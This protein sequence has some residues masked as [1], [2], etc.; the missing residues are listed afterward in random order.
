[1]ATRSREQQL[2]RYSAVVPVTTTALQTPSLSDTAGLARGVFIVGNDGSVDGG[3]IAPVTITRPANTTAYSAVDVVGGVL[4]ISSVGPAS[5]TAILTGTRLEL[6]IAAV[7][8]GM[9]YFTLHIYSATP[10]S[11]YADNAAWDL[12]S[13][14]RSVY[15]GNVI[16]GTPVDLG[17]TLYVEIN[18]INK[19]LKLVGGS[20]LYGYLVTATGYTPASNSEVYKLT[21]ATAAI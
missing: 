16:V 3:Y 1:M 8:T 18:N 17:S 4:T 2:D 11:A 9:T 14:D 13:G 19:M 20:T 7:P 10:P 5:S 15:M 12:P 6:D 21:L